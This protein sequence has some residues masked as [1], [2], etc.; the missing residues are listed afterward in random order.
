MIVS[1][2]VLMLLVGLLWAQLELGVYF[3]YVYV[4]WPLGIM[5]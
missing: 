4:T 2:V 3:L 1:D 5:C